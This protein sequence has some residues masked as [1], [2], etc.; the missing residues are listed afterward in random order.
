MQMKRVYPSE[1][2]ALIFA[3]GEYGQNPADGVW[4]LRLP[5]FHTGSLENHHVTEHEDGT[6]TVS[7]SILHTDYD[8]RQAHGFLEHGIWRNA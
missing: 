4:Y 6:I 3:G 2:G 8:G 7:P 5:G 1:T